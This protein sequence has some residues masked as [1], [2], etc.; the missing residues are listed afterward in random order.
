MNFALYIS[1]VIIYITL[2]KKGIK[3]SIAKIKAA[4]KALNF[5]E[6]NMI[7]ALGSGSTAVEFIKLLADKVKKGLSIKCVAT[8]FDS[9]ILA[10]NLGIQVVS[11]DMI[12]KIDIAVDGAD[13]IAPNGLLKGGGGACTLEKIID[14]YAEKFIVI[15]DESKLKDSLNGT[16]V[17]EVLP[18]A[19]KS[20]MKMF[21]GSKLRMAT[22]KMGP[23][24]TDNGNFLIDIDM[25][26]DNPVETEQ[27]IN[28]IPGVVENGIF[29]KFDTVIIG[30][31]NSAKI[32]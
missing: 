26:I 5:I 15:A 32:L 23:V 2:N 6:N 29:T 12:D 3:M 17:I 13:V 30:M 1:I 21:T 24:I 4:E 18:V 31:E 22:K 27:K 16:V 20:V 7:V 8:S 9:S 25:N 14:Y 10:N 11:F 19:Y 28:T